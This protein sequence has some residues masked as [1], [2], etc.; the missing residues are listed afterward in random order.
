MHGQSL[1]PAKCPLPYRLCD[2]PWQEY[3]I[4][5]A[6][7]IID[8]GYVIS[9]PAHEWVTGLIPGDACEIA[10]NFDPSQG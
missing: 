2:F 5:W 8:S 7:C 6:R 10:R 9:R 4:F 1:R 3:G